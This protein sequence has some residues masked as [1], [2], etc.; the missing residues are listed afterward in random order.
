MPARELSV[1]IVGLDGAT[2]DLMLPWIDEGHLP[3]L[4]RLLRS[5][6]R[7]RLESTIPPITPCAWSSFIT[8]KNPGK[9]GLFDFV[10]PVGDG[11]GFRFTNASFRDGESLWA[12]LSRHGQRVGVVNVPMTYPPEPVNGFLIS[13][14]DTPHEHSAFMHPV[15]IRQELKEAGIRYRIDQQHLGNMRTNERRRQQLLDIFESETARTAAFR[16]LSELRPAN[17]RMIVYG[18]TDQVQHHFWHFMDEA[19]D[20]HDPVG[21]KEFRHA[22]RET[23]QHIDVQLGQLLDECDDDTVVIIMSDHGFG[24]MSNVRVR[25]NQ[26]LRDAGLL[27]FVEPSPGGRWKQAFASTLDRVLRSTLSSD[28]K[29]TIAGLLPRLRVWFENL[30][31]AKI[32]W[33]STSAYV[34][35]AYRSSPAIWLVKGDGTVNGEQEDL[36]GCVEN[37]LVSLVDPVTGE[38]LIS[39]CHRPDEIY[40]GPHKAKAPAIL[41]SWWEDGFLLEQSSPGKTAPPN[42]ERSTA[43]I[44]GGV[45][46]AA[47][48]RLDGVLMLSGGPIRQD[49]AF[50]GAKIVDVAPTVLYLM[51][52]PVP[53]DMD[54]R[55]LTEAID[56][57]F[58]ELNPVRRENLDE[59]FDEDAVDDSRQSFTEQESELIARRL[60]ALGYIQ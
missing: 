57:D 29:R 38:Q 12:C 20:K 25:L 4:G 39:N 55:V 56:E 16:H 14:L 23:Y 11:S 53:D 51:G 8:G 3:N 6:S 5:G 49:L 1:L 60:Q 47:S 54:G 2:F 31:E 15:E 17:F 24:P 18:S 44:Q 7:S 19:H 30:D 33:P 13:G 52:L 21:A 41:P 34:N 28:A 42:V 50:T 43:P 40:D 32:D 10:E 22:I 9:H 59:E 48:H 27:K 26:V 45:E 36:R 58:L 37:V 35:E 46:F